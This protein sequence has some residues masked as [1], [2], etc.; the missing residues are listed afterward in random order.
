[1]SFLAWRLA[2]TEGALNPFRAYSSLPQVTFGPK[3]LKLPNTDNS[4]SPS[5]A[6]ELPHDRNPVNA[7]KL[8]A[9]PVGLS[10][11][12][13]CSK[14][15]NTRCSAPVTL[16]VKIFAVATAA[17]IEGATYIFG[18]SAS[19]IEVQNSEDIK[20][21]GKELVQPKMEMLREQLTPL[22]NW[23]GDKQKKWHWE[24][25]RTIKEK[26][27]GKELSRTMGPKTPPN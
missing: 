3:R 12:R 22:K 11:N 10:R 21:K 20:A 25:E 7:E 2:G 13:I 8:K 16:D 9:A 18:L 17:V 24:R 14:H 4:V 19:K 1:M 26:P 27:I 15:A 5:T 6:N 23:V